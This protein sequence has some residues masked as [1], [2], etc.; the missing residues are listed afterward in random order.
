MTT[1]KDTKDA[2]TEATGRIHLKQGPSWNPITVRNSM[3]STVINEDAGK[4]KP[5]VD[6]RADQSFVPAKTS[7]LESFFIQRTID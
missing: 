4:R 1:A 7:P 3:A 6:L 5:R 2:K